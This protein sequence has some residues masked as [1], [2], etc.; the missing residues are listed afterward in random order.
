MIVEYDEEFFCVRLRRLK[1]DEKPFAVIQMEDLIDMWLDEQDEDK[2]RKKAFKLVYDDLT[3]ISGLFCGRY[4]ARHGNSGYMH[5]ISTVMECIAY[6]VSDEQGEQF[7]DM[8]L[9]NMVKS[10]EKAGI[11]F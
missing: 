1:F 11:D 10:R 2:K 7:E 8:F 6:N 5:G 9:N 4:D 3:K